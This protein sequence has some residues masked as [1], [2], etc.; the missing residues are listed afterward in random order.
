MA[1]VRYTHRFYAEFAKEAMQSQSLGGTDVI[2]IKW[3][4]DDSDKVVK[5]RDEEQREIFVK[6][7]KRKQMV[8]EQKAEAVRA[9]EETEKRQ[10]EKLKAKQKRQFEKDV[11][12]GN[13]Y[14]PAYYR[15]LRTRPEQKISAEAQKELDEE[16]SK[17]T[18][19]CAR[20]NEVLHRISCNYQDNP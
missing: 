16:R 18:E 6:A 13:V 1:N 17:V 15:E 2:T 14:N 4:L 11:S 7:V 3:S 10:L 5:N 8:E 12:G 20:L 19:N 9:A